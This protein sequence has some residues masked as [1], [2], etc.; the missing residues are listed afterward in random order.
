MIDRA[1]WSFWSRPFAHDAGQRWASDRFHLLSGT[2]SVCTVGSQFGSTALVTDDAGARLLVDRLGLPFDSVST[3]LEAL[4][5]SDHRWW[6]LGKLQAYGEQ[7]RPFLH[8]DN[9]TYLWRPLP[10]ALLSSDLL[11][12]NPEYAPT[13]DVTFYK[14]T[15]FTASVVGRGGVLPP[16]WHAYVRGGGATAIC[17][18]VFGGCDVDSIRRYA[19]RATSTIQRDE[20]IA[21]W[22]AIGVGLPEQVLME[23]YYLAAFWA[24]VGNDLGRRAQITYL[25][26]SLEEAYGRTVS[27]RLGFTHLIA[28]AKRSP[29][30]EQMVAA[31]LRTDYPEQYERV[32]AVADRSP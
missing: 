18:G 5:R 16:E 22:R 31:R 23:Q 26:S 3:S 27:R 30:L 20:N 28:G 1:V 2:L 6:I 14:P 19:E 13:S 29:V 15:A 25:F 24:D 12:Q 32:H 21:V 4:H 10:A 9:D 7:E 11:A 17:T 8:F